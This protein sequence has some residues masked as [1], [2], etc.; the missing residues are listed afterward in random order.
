M[1]QLAKGFMSIILAI[2]I[3]VLG[4]VIYSNTRHNMEVLETQQFEN[5]TPEPVI[6]PPSPTP[7][8][9]PIVEGENNVDIKIAVCGDIVAHSGLIVEAEK[10]DGTHDFNA[11]MNG[12]ASLVQSADFSLVTLETTFPNTTEY[13]GYPMFKSPAG[14]AK[15][16]AETGFDLINTAN[17]HSMDAYQSG[18]IRT[19]DVLDEN[20]LGHIGTYRTQ[21]E[22]DATNGVYARE[23][24]GISIAFLSYTYGTNGLPVSGFEYAVN[25]FYND[26]LTTLSDINYDLLRADMAYARSLET[27]LIIPLMHWGHEYQTVPHAYQNELADFLFAEGADI[28]LG[29]HV[30]V[31]QP[32]EL[33]RVVDNEGNEKTGFIAYCLGN[34]ISCQNDPFTNITAALELSVRKN[35]DSGETYIRHVSY[36]PLFMVDLHDYGVTDAGWRYRLW[37]LNAAIADYEGGNDWGVINQSF[38]NAMKNDLDRLHSVMPSEFDE[39]NGGVNV[40]EWTA[41]NAG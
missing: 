1:K 34:F 33:R 13:T 5:A 19:L 31:P 41:A 14:L 24:N 35:L 3:A 37:D 26:Y 12:A 15:S 6:L 7:T 38:Y 20:G 22:R 4:F 23:I 29:G 2:L 11:I 17:N 27:D 10:S 25:I 28:I 36:K 9:P 18:I 16:L 40:V 39:A 30:H 21:E 32:M 8:E